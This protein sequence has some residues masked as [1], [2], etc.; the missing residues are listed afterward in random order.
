[1]LHSTYFNFESWFGGIN[2]DPVKK[3]GVEAWLAANRF[4]YTSSL[5]DLQVDDLNGCPCVAGDK[6]AIINAAK[7]LFPSEHKLGKL[8]CLSCFPCDCYILLSLV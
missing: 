3:E 6:K 8:Y 4:S 2:I 1:M 7:E 5:K